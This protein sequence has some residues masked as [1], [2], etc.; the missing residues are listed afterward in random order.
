M[1]QAIGP[2][3]VQDVLALVAVAL[4]AVYLCRRL[5]GWPGPRKRAEVAA[6][7]RVEIG[8]RLARGLERAERRGRRA[9][10]E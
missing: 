4:A 3:G 1:S 5:T 7:T 2:I 9:S 10:A 8:T 6:N